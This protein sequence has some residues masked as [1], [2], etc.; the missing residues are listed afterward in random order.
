[1]EANSRISGVDP[2]D[3]EGVPATVASKA[4]RHN[5]GASPEEGQWTVWSWWVAGVCHENGRK[6]ARYFLHYAVEERALAPVQEGAIAPLQEHC[7]ALKLVSEYLIKSVTEYACI[8]CIYPVDMYFV[9]WKYRLSRMGNTILTGSGAGWS[10]NSPAMSPATA[11]LRVLG[12]AQSSQGERGG[13]KEDR[14]TIFSLVLLSKK[15]CGM[16]W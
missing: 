9:Y 3:Q 2:A 16:I 13:E 15:K 14:G 10:C 1:M 11:R 6:T 7:L 4:W 12:W 8:A 5:T